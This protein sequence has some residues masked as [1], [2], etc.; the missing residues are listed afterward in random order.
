M[1]RKIFLM[2]ALILASMQMVFAQDNLEWFPATGAKNMGFKHKIS[3][4]EYQT[5]RVKVKEETSSTQVLGVT[6]KE[7]HQMHYKFEQM[8]GE[9]AAKVEV[10]ENELP[11]GINEW[12]KVFNLHLGD[13]LSFVASIV[14]PDKTV[15]AFACDVSG[16]D[17][18]FNCG[19]IVSPDGKVAFTIFGNNYSS[20]KDVML[21]RYISYYE[22]REGDKVV[23]RVDTKEDGKA[24][25]DPSLDI[26]SKLLVSSVLTCYLLRKW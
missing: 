16:R 22:V 4:G 10:C 21:H 14:L 15:W 19:S 18:G 24:W 12:N 13:S 23:G 7:T 9:T 26:N 8:V 1:K 6:V 20:P 3:Y 5:S 2:A 25:V 11:E 17:Q